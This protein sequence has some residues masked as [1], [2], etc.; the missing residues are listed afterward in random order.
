[1]K[2][3]LFSGTALAVALLLGAAQPQAQQQGQPNQ[4]GAANRA[5]TPGRP[6]VPDSDVDY[7]RSMERLFQAAQRLRE[8]V[9]SMAQQPAGERRNQAMAQ[10]REALLHT[11]QAMVS[12]PPNLRT[13]QNYRDA[14]QRVG[15]AERAL[16][17]NQPDPQ[18][19]GSAVDALLVL[20]PR[21]QAEAGGAQVVVREASP[22][23]QVQQAQPQ[24]TVQQ[25]QP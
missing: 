15:E 12:L 19:A 10:A 23:V 9:Q 24:V 2:K 5:E 6:A 13:N 21:L 7:T 11:Q 22:T 20:V 4:G 17:G 25:P 18:R 1:M 16:Q 14:E 3:Q 8:S